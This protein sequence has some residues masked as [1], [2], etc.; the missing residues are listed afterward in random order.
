MTDNFKM[1]W[2]VPQKG[3]GGGSLQESFLSLHPVGLG[4]ELG[5][6]ALAGRAFLSAEPSHL[7][8][9]PFR[10]LQENVSWLFHITLASSFQYFIILRTDDSIKQPSPIVQEGDLER[11]ISQPGRYLAQSYYIRMKS[12][13]HGMWRVIW[14]EILGKWQRTRGQSTPKN[15]F[16]K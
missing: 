10:F 12:P 8:W 1:H 2:W 5:S 11:P 9:I 6:S 13:G 15:R 14:E 3:G 7:P 16:K 4:I